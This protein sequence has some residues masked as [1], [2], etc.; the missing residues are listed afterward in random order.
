MGSGFVIEN[1]V[2]LLIINATLQFLVSS[3]LGVLL[4]VPMQSW[5]KGLTRHVASMADLRG[6]HLDW[7]M[8]GLMQYGIAFGLHTMPLPSSGLI[9]CLLVF[10]GWM[11]AFPYLVRGLFGINAFTLGGPPRQIVCALIGLTS[12][13]SLIT[14][15]TLLVLGWLANW[16][17]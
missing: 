1:P 10:G 7:L 11:N 6:T 12:I 17:H 16:P 9:A 2:R 5:G 3:L 15:F 4:L 14:A 13:S 8:L